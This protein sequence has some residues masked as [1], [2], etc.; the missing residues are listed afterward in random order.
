LDLLWLALFDYFVQRCFGVIV[1]WCVLHG[2]LFEV[3]GVVQQIPGAVPSTLQNESR[4][5]ENRTFQKRN[6]NVFL[7]H[8][9]IRC[10]FFVVGR[11]AFFFSGEVFCGSL[12]RIVV[13]LFL[14]LVF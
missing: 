6:T 10:D 1:V 3:E 4:R 8:V 12:V 14:L 13:V 2:R 11:I 5:K 9:A 7:V